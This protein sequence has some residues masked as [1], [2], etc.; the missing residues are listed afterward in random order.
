MDRQR[1]GDESAGEGKGE[2]EDLGVEAPEGGPG[3]W[4]VWSARVRELL[5]QILDGT[6]AAI[7]VLDTELR[8]RYVNATLAHMNGVP[9][10]EH[11]GRTV[12]EVV[13]GVDPREDVLRAVIA[14]GIPRETISSG[15]TQADSPWNAATG[16][17]PTT[18]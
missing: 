15:H 1:A 2:S 17:A 3:F 13:P 4:H 7:A 18:G 5:G 9:A 6:P 12:A 14:D 16:T 8:F 11:I 10:K